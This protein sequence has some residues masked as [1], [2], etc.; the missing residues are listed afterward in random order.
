MAE[1]LKEYWQIAT[2]LILIFLYQGERVENDVA[3][4]ERERDKWQEI[5]DKR[6]ED[7]Q[8][9]KE[10][11]ISSKTLF[12]QKMSK[13]DSILKTPV[14]VETVEGKSSEEIDNIIR[15]VLNDSL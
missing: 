9:W 3:E 8:E 11:Y 12:R 13:V 1:F 5:A 2:I 6:Y 4:L 10:K 14:E 15:S 7:S